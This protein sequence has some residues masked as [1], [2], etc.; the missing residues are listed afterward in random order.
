[1][2]S[3]LIVSVLIVSV[4]IVLEVNTM[5]T[6]PVL[7]EETLTTVAKGFKTTLFQ[8]TSETLYDRLNALRAW[9]NGLQLGYEIYLE[10]EW[11]DP[12]SGETRLEYRLRSLRTYDEL[13]PLG[14]DRYRN[15]QDSKGVWHLGDYQ[16]TVLTL[17]EVSIVLAFIRADQQILK[18]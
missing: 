13:P 3:V 6:W 1:L 17:A 16:D 2:H 14:Y 9:F 8:Q 18:P 5:A 4:L 15:H 12:V 11:N 10:D 7:S